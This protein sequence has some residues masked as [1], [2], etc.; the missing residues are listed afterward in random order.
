MSSSNDRGFGKHL[1]RPA[2]GS[3]PEVDKSKLTERQEEQNSPVKKAAPKSGDR[4]FGRL[5]PEKPDADPQ[6]PS[7]PPP[8]M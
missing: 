8:R 2:K 4:G 3:T 7:G 5:L 6:R 1:Q